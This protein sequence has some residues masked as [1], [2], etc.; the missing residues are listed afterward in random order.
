MTL[1]LTRR[2]ALLSAAA[3]S[4]AL[5]LPRGLRAQTVHE[6]QMLNRSPDDPSVMQ[7]FS[8]RLLVVEPGDTVH[9][10]AT[11]K[12]HNSASIKGMVPEG[13]E[14]WKGKMNQDIEVTLTQPGF[15]GYE[16]TPH[17]AMGMVGLIVVRG[18]GL[19]DSMATAREAKLRGR[20]G[21]VF[22]EIWAEVEAMDLGA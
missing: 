6:V 4:A 3:A 7:V 16:C 12:T 11:D 10:V 21:D 22:D 2:A 1:L 9:F 19:M 14:G 13:A 17:H 5:V 18:E 20:A 15:Y 8:P